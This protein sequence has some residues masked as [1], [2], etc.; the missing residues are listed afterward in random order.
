MSDPA[1]D[2]TGEWT[3]IFNYPYR[4]PSTQFQASLRDHGG[5]ISGVTI[6]P[7]L[8]PQGDGGTLHAVLEG[9]REGSLVRFTKTYDDLRHA[10]DVIHYEGQVDQ[11][12]DEIAGHW[13]IPGMW[14]GT[15]LMIRASRTD[16]K[17]ARR[18]SEKV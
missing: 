17:A 7:D 11:S 18:V 8:E 16:E 4:F 6:E 2:L 14:S 1:E 3:G 9:S 5:L 15:F 13:T 10:A 12:G